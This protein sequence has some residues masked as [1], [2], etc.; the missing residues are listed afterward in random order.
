[1]D[2]GEVLGAVLGEVS[3]DLPGLAPVE[4]LLDVHGG[5]AEGLEG[6]DD[7]GHVE[8][9]LEVKLHRHRL[10]AVRGLQTLQG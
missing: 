3:V 8:L 2:P 9:G 1:M 5:G 10:V 6:D 7:V 4:R